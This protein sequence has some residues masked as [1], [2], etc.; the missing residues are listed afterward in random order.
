ME[1][2]GGKYRQP[3]EENPRRDGRD[4]NRSN[5]TRIR[6]ALPAQKKVRYTQHAH[7][8]SNKEMEVLTAVR[9]IQ[10]P[11]HAN[12]PSHATKNGLFGVPTIMEVF[13]HTTADTV[14][15]FAR[16]SRLRYFAFAATA[17]WRRYQE[18]GMPTGT[19][20]GETSRATRRPPPRHRFIA[21][22]QYRAV[23]VHAAR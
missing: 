1:A 4:R 5:A 2:K 14:Q 13:R 9:W 7:R 6:T 17:A 23:Q 20:T 15:A 11:I 12:R 18:R 22:R 21:E 3:G 8:L 19:A 10:Q 16:S